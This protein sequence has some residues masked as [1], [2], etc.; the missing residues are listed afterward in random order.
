MT[1][2]SALIIV[3]CFAIGGYF[4]FFTDK[5][6]AP[7]EQAAESVLLGEE[8]IAV[9]FSAAKKKKLADQQAKGSDGKKD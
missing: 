6:D 5:I 8:N 3:A 1:L 7:G 4:E 2:L 9:D